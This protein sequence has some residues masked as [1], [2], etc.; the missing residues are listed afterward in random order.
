[1]AGTGPVA[2]LAG[3]TKIGP[4]GCVRISREIVVLFQICR[5]AFGALVVPRL[6]APGPMQWRPWRKLLVG[7]KME[8]ALTALLLRPRIPREP[9]HLVA[10]VRKRYHILL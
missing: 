10:P 1:M 8:P 6:I 7:V 4:S 5:V 9:E 2:S 3:H